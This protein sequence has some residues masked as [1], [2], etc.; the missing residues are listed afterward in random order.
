MTYFNK[1]LNGNIPL[2]IIGCINGYND[3]YMMNKDFSYLQINESNAFNKEIQQMLESGHGD[4]IRKSMKLTRDDV[5]KGTTNIFKLSLSDTKTMCNRNSSY[6]IKNFISNFVNIIES[7]KMSDYSKKVFL[8]IIDLTGITNKKEKILLDL[9]LTDLKSNQ[10]ID[11]ADLF[12]KKIKQL[13]ENGESKFDDTFISN[14][15]EIF[16]YIL[17]QIFDNIIKSS[18]HENICNFYAFTIEIADMLASN[19]IEHF[20][21][22]GSNK[23]D[24]SVKMS[25]VEELKKN[26]N[27]G[28]VIKGMTKLLSSS[29]TN[30]MSSNT[31]DIMAVIKAENNLALS[32]MKTKGAFTLTGIN[33]NSSV[34]S[35]TD[36]TVTQKITTKIQNDI[37]NELSKSIKNATSNLVS[38][39]STKEKTDTGGSS[40]QGTLVG[41]ADVVGETFGKFAEVAGDMVSIGAEKSVDNSKE[42]SESL[43]NEL[44][45]DSSFKTDTNNEVNTQLQNLLDSK[46]IAKVG[47]DSLSKNNIDVKDIEAEGPILISDISQNSVVS[48]ITNAIFTQEVLNE[49]STKI[50]NSLNEM[51]ANM[52]EN[53]DKNYNVD[54]NTVSGGDIQALGAA[55]AAILAGAGE[56][57]SS[58]ATGLGTGISTSATGLGEGVSS[59]A[60]GL[61]TGLSTT[62]QGL[63]TGIATSAKGL[64]SMFS[65][66]ALPL[67]FFACI[68]A[69]GG[70]FY[71]KF[72]SPGTLASL[73]SVISPP[74]QYPPQ[75]Y[76]PQQYS[77]QQYGGSRK[78]RS[79]K[80]IISNI[81][82]TLKKNNYLFSD[83]YIG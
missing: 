62:A 7:L 33:Q 57:I 27:Q 72:F 53:A 66:M 37:S 83:N 18:K 64:G 32:G 17:E 45:L 38:S 68:A 35:K 36:A 5:V 59:A 47:N 31:A 34:S 10:K 81:K 9:E 73:T 29:I 58:A 77:P 80:K 4:L 52:A 30:A 46:N 22:G 19:V 6:L 28:A 16:I 43:K 54:K 2:N 25:K 40:I 82:S 71:L 14:L 79:N 15:S 44:N 55:G 13:C 26:I 69:V 24:N 56:G 3:K 48:N 50:V 11:I 51:V 23:T 60:Q 74:Q 21:F 42:I 61:G 67:F 76:P 8:S 63:G 65:S 39:T 1:I 12:S 70:Y 75:Q 20:A 78:L 49:I 41:L